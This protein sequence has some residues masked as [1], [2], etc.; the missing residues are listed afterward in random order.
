MNQNLS[1][2]AA[3][4]VRAW[5]APEPKP[6]NTGRVASVPMTQKDV[7]MAYGMPINNLGTLLASTSGACYGTYLYT[8]RKSGT[9][10]PG[11]YVQPMVLA[12][13]RGRPLHILQGKDEPQ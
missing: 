1:D 12:G 9:L 11:R 3:A 4:E 5:S 6:V 8:S 10:N 2:V 7:S 13:A